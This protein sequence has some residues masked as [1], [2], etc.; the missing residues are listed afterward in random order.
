MSSRSNVNDRWYQLQHFLQFV[1]QLLSISLEIF[2][3]AILALV[4]IV[5]PAP[6]LRVIR[7]TSM[8]AG[9]TIRGK[10]SGTPYRLLG[11]KISEFVP[12]YMT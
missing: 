12:N 11:C 2:L 3:L 6:R 4:Q 7:L 10:I 5:Q 8:R 9:R 1:G